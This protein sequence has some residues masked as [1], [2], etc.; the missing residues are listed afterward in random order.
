MMRMEDRQMNDGTSIEILRKMDKIISLLEALVPQEHDATPPVFPSFPTASQ[1]KCVKCG[2]VFDG[3]TSYVC[4]F[5]D[6]PMG[7]GPVA[8]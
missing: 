8:C 5:T 2:M 1:N 4:G 7:L 3:T 6:C